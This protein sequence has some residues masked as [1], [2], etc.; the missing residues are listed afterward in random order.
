MLI[1][2]DNNL[3]MFCKLKNFIFNV[4]PPPRVTRA[5]LDQTP[6]LSMLT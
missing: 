6:P 1:T 2:F 3:F 5:L 4:L